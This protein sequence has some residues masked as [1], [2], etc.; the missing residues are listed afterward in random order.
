MLANQPLS[1]YNLST[2]NTLRRKTFMRKT[3]FCKGTET[4]QKCLLGEILHS[5]S[6]RK[7]C[8][9]RINIQLLNTQ[10]IFD[11]LPGA[12]FYGKNVLYIQKY[13]CIWMC[14]FGYIYV[15]V[16]LLLF[17][18][19]WRQHIRVMKTI[20]VWCAVRVRYSRDSGNADSQFVVY[21]TS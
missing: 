12:Y 14:T 16:V 17:L 7:C 8:A 21:P 5:A 13:I 6:I 15:Y 20:L 2:V 11:H 9:T 1:L 10:K 19:V 18:F 4:R 3:I